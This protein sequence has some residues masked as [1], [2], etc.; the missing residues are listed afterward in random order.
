MQILVPTEC[1]NSGQ[2]DSRDAKSCPPQNMMVIAVFYHIPLF[3]GYTILLGGFKLRNEVLD[4]SVLEA[5]FIGHSMDGD[6]IF[7][8]SQ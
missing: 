1:M 3:K 2:A 7:D 5:I 8:N 6:L 4:L